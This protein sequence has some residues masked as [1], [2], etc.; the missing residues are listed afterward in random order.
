MRKDKTM[1]DSSLPVAVKEAR[2]VVQMAKAAVDEGSLRRA[3]L[4]LHEGR[5]IVPC[6]SSGA[7]HE[8][9]LAITLEESTVAQ[10][11][12]A[13]ERAWSLADVA[14][15]LADESF[16]P[17]GVPIARARLLRNF[18]MEAQRQFPEA[19]RE[20]LELADELVRVPG[21]DGLRLNCLT[22][23]IA[24]AVKNADR[25]QLREI[26]MQAFP[27]WEKLNKIR[28]HGIA[29]W[30]LFWCAVASLRQHQV[31]DAMRLLERAS[32]IGDPYW[33]WENAMHFA[34]GHGMALHEGT[35]RQG[36]AILEAAHED[37][38]NRGF[39][40]HVKSIDAGLQ[41]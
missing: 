6:P 27:L 8:A 28:E 40:G 34:I 17:R 7:E 31:G 1:L 32:V 38:K 4:L 33:R 10:Y 29:R 26:G 12:G 19:M 14:V 20:N 21:S 15:N 22:R 2:H 37:A 3:E 23:A 5:Q 25:G 41:D 35:E 36:L 9:S 11:G 13:F 18:A 39:H 16:G 30:F 24:C